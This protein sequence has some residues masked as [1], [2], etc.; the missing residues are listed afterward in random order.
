MRASVLLMQQVLICLKLALIAH[1]ALCS[2][3]AGGQEQDEAQS[4]AHTILALPS[5]EQGPLL[6]Q[7]PFNQRVCACVCVCVYAR[8][9]MLVLESLHVCVYACVGE[10][11]L[12]SESFCQRSSCLSI[13][14][15]VRGG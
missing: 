10:L 2:H 4:I 13:S 7:L 9:C 11:L 8:V 3:A 12:A 14:G 1:A 6:A 5:E 15:C